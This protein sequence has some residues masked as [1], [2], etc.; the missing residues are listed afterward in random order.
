M[1]DSILLI[2]EANIC[3][4]PMAQA[5]LTKRLPDAA[6][7]SAGTRAMP[8]RKADAFAMELMAERGLDLSMHS[9][10]PVD[11]RQIRSAQL[12]L[13]MTLAQRKVIEG[14]FPF[15]RG[16]VYRLGEHDGFDVSDPYR[17]PRAVYEEALTKI[18]TGIDNWIQG[19]RTCN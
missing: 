14:I 3:R 10:N 12:V 11:L 16:K 2:C 13:T 5:I 18:E 15:A 1:I 4:S 17:G 7:V 6:I 19:I 8:G 9:S